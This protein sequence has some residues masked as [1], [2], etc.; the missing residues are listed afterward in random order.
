MSGNKAFKLFGSVIAPKPALI[1]SEPIP[2][3][4]NGASSPSSD[5]IASPTNPIHLP[6]STPQNP[7]NKE[8]LPI[9]EMTDSIYCTPPGT[10]YTHSTFINEG[11]ITPIPTNPDLPTDTYDASPSSTTV[12]I[13]QEPNDAIMGKDAKEQTAATLPT[14][15]LL[16]ISNSITKSEHLTSPIKFPRHSSPAIAITDS[17]IEDALAN[18]TGEDKLDKRKSGEK[19]GSISTRVNAKSTS[20]W[21]GKEFSFKEHKKTYLEIHDTK[22]LT[23]KIQYKDKYAGSDASKTSPRSEGIPTLL[24]LFLLFRF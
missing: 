9:T 23:N 6:A 7:T 13:K 3:T 11:T 22:H 16:G 17:V 10:L 2:T 5:A 20:K 4:P 1:K 12:P 19:K 8:N 21:S 15:D 24:L 18:C 14:S